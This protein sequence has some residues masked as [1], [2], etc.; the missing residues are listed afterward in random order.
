MA[1]RVLT[2]RGIKIR[3][4]RA[5]NTLKRGLTDFNLG[6]RDYKAILNI[7]DKNLTQ[8]INI[9]K[10][11]RILSLIEKKEFKKLSMFKILKDLKQIE[12]P[13]IKNIATILQSDIEFYIANQDLIL[14]HNKLTNQQRKDRRLKVNRLLELEYAKHL[15]IKQ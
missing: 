2:H 3:R 10:S 15:K 6:A 4:T 8:K 7:L 11:K 5:L 1:R 14:E 9:K 12:K 13:N